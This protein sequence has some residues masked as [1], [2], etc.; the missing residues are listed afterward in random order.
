MLIADVPAPPPIAR[1]AAV[2]EDGR[3][4]EGRALRLVRRGSADAPDRVLVVG[5]MHG[6][7]AGG[8][9]VI[10]ALRATP[11]PASTEIFTIADLNPDGSRRG[12]RTNARGVDLN[13]NFPRDWRPGPRGRFFPG[14]R[15][16]S[17]PETSWLQR[18]VAAVRPR[19]TV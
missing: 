5:G 12:R 2:V 9:L 13:R 7:E 18:V 3:N 10:A 6:D 11:A 8:R 17:E 15:A 16:A 4:V 14:S 19:V 1:P